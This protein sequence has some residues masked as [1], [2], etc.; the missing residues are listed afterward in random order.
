MPPPL[1]KELIP[2]GRRLN[3]TILSGIAGMV[4]MIGILLFSLASE[5]QN[6]NQHA[7]LEVENITQ[8]LEE[9]VLATFNSAD[10]LLR[11]VQRTVRLDDIRHFD[12]ISR[13]RE[14]AL[15]ALLKS[16][17][18]SVPAVAVIRI[19]NAKGDN[20]YS[21]LD[22]IPHINIS[23][24]KYFQRQ[25][26]DATAGLVISAPLISRT[27]GKWTFILSRRLNFKD[28]SFAGIILV[29]L[30][31][32][33]FQHLY[34][35]LNLGTDGLVAL[36]DSDLRLAARY[37]SSEI[38]MGK[39]ANL[40]AKKYIDKGIIHT[41][42]HAK[43]AL[44][45]I[46]RIIG[47]RKVGDL[48]LI[49]FAGIAEDDYL[50]QWHRHIWQYGFGAMIFSFVVIGFVLLQRRA[51][52]SL[53]R[54]EVKSKSDEDQIAYLALYDRLTGLPNR[55]LLTDRLNQ[56]LV[57][58]ARSGKKGALLFIDLDNFKTV[59]DTRGYD[60]A[61]LILKQAAQRLE[62]CVRKCD[63]VSRIDGD[64]FIVLLENLS[65]KPLE[66]A[67][68]TEII[69][70]KI[71]TTLSQPYRI[72]AYEHHGSA[73]I[74]VTLFNGNQLGTDELLKQADIAMYQAKKAGRNTL[75]F[76]DP[77]MQA[78]ITARVSLE[79]E[80]RKALELQQFHLYYQIQVDSSHHPLGA[81]A[82]IRWIHPLRGVVPP[83]QFIPL[84]EETGLILPIGQWVL[85]TAC[86]QLN[87]WQQDVLTR[88]LV[89]AVNVSARQFRQANFVA[90]VKV[91]VQQH[92]INPKLLKLELTEGMLLENI[93]ET[94]ATMNALKEIGIGFSLDDFGTGYS[95]LQYLKRLPLD[96]LKI[97]QSF[98]RDIATDSDD[99]AIVLTIV[100]MAQSLGIHVIAEGVETNQQQQLLLDRGC[101]YYQ[102]YLFGK[103]VPIE[104]FET[105]LRHR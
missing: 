40:H 48:P 67:A 6:E 75:R 21:S 83:D 46:Q 79:G 98:V 16:Q 15:H 68:Q 97:D 71:L 9:N 4:G 94:I 88:D 63:S 77:Q 92:G 1:Q 25:R 49:V 3:W 65:T 23:D 87:V 55:Q 47:Y 102:G 99:K 52:D 54:S 14:Q 76:F 100:T 30:D 5:Y 101:F 31:L 57:A 62:L 42:Y 69:G 32:N 85:E 36:F 82:L 58:S 2:Y 13:S 45:N 105:L 37:P 12:G 86:A 22:W 50:S 66:A 95:S 39:I 33:Y 93:E 78:S 91:I 53:R 96:Q 89:L 24:R 103:P 51:E 10:L 74:G 43:A 7:E 72:D 90:Q 20:L 73:S 104:Q 18:D 17:V 27:T 26:A 70:E 19:T 56:A 61:D 34:H 44:D 60:M 11:E 81:E 64:E 8:V 84:A 80:L 59:I 28:G 38:N 35:T 41:V 29:I